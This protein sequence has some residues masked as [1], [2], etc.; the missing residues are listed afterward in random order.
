MDVYIITLLI[1]ALALVICSAFFSSAETAFFSL[2]P[3][4]LRKI[5]QIKPVDGEKVQNLLSK[6]TQ[7]LSTILI[8]NTIVNISIATIGFIV[9]EHYFPKRGEAV[10]IVLVTLLLIIFGEAAPKRM[11]LIFAER[12]SVFYVPLIHLLIKLFK[13]LR[14]VLE[15]IT[16]T[17]EPFFRPHGRTLS[18]EE[19]H[20][21]LEISNEEGIIN[22]DELAM[23]KAII[24]L[25][26]LKAGNI[27]TPHVDLVAFDLSGNK[28]DLLALAR[29]S[30][31]KYILLYNDNLDD[32]EGFLDA[33]KFLLDP[34]HDI[35]PAKIPPFFVPR[36]SMLPQLLVQFQKSNR[37]IAVVV[38]EY[39]GTAGI[40]TRGDVLEEITGEIYT[41][42]SRPR[43]IFQQAG[44]YRWLLDPNF[45]L[46]EINRKLRL[47]LSADGVERLS[48]WITA[49]LGHIPQRDEVVEAQGCRVTVRQAMKQRITLV[50]L[51]MLE[52]QQ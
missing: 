14:M 45:S 6:P 44:P 15:K 50:E 31:I 7:I 43:Q 33:R 36:N 32:V 3:L 29:K 22:A 19:F 34:E 51:E 8:G 16:K 39:G 52:K 26:N 25:E 21:V 1:V 5:K 46:D 4:N 24:N 47:N 12:L 37:R 11:G 20:T 42:L 18:E 38:D 9:A 41:E 13:P 10:S 48:G 23:I 17:F 27:M 28:D 35:G 30:K 49:S 2:N 40:V